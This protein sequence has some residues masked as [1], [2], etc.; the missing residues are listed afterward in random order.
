MDIKLFLI[1]F[2]T[3]NIYAN[4]DFLSKWNKLI[5][6]DKKLNIVNEE[7]YLSNKKNRSNKKELESTINLLNSDIGQKIACNYPARYTFLKK[8]NAKIPK[9]NLNNCAE[10]KN[11]KNNFKS[12][13]ISLVFTSKFINSP[14]SSFGH[15]MLIFNN[16]NSSIELADTIHFAGKPSKNDN[17]FLYAYKG[18]VAQYNGYFIRESFFKKI[19]QY[20]I[21]EQRFMHIY[22]LNYTKEEIN[23]LIYHLYELRKTTFKYDF[24][25]GNCSSRLLELLSILDKKVLN[26]NSFAYLPIDLVKDLSHRITNNSKLLPLINKLTYIINEMNEKELISFKH[27]IKNNQIPPTNISNKVKEALVYHAVFNFRKY[28]RSFKNYDEIMNLSYSGI[29]IKKD[30]SH[31]LINTQAS[32][33]GI[34]YIKAKSFN[35]LILNYRP[36]LIDLK[37]IQTDLIQESK[38]SLFELNFLVKNQNIKLNKFDLISIQ[39]LPIQTSFH[40]PI[41]W[42]IYSGLTR[43]NKENDLKL[44]NEFGIG[45]TIDLYKNLNFSFLLNIG[46]ENIDAYVK[47]SVRFSKYLSNNIK[48][49]ASSYFK[50]YDKNEYFENQIF[51]S[52]KRNNILYTVNYINDKSVDK[53]KY[54]FSIKYNF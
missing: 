11:F 17:F 33:I 42:S 37:D 27:I 24:L 19:Y 28:H 26:H 7:F 25:V 22:D 35:G 54:L 30:N 20:N 41:S 50:Q 2:V 31:P 52:I 21:L 15:T 39:A 29:K 34:S 4:G 53:N 48:V 10:L 38:L 45:R 36:L 44:N 12:D 16:I 1:L 43:E 8:N 40:K 18:L 47:P 51:T 6:F 13:K 3:V 49:G 14:S 32:N 46:L 5:H 23:F 9:Y